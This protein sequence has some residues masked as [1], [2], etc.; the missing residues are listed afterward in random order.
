[1]T[2][3]TPTQEAQ[4]LLNNNASP[5]SNITKREVRAEYDRLVRARQ[6]ARHAFGSGL[7]REDLSPGAQGEYDRLVASRERVSAEITLRA[8]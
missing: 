7:P 8:P 5:P 6:E 4:Y 1:M 2:K 3:M